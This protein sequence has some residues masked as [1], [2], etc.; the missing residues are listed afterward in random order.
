MERVDPAYRAEEMPCRSRVKA[1]LGELIFTF[2]HLN[3]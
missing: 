2:G 1:I 3:A